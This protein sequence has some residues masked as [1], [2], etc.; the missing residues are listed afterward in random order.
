M[1]WGQCLCFGPVIDSQLCVLVLSH[2]S[3]VSLHSIHFIE[4][5]ECSG[6]SNM[7][8]LYFSLVTVLNCYV[9]GPFGHILLLFVKI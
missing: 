9:R 3:S 5:S 6:D 1:G 2:L 7:K 8:W 4:K